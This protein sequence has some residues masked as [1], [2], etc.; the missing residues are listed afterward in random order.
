MSTPQQSTTQAH[1]LE[2]SPG[3]QISL[4][5]EPFYRWFRPS[6]ASHGDCLRPRARD[7]VHLGASLRAEGGAIPSHLPAYPTPRPRPANLLAWDHWDVG[8]AGEPA[9]VLAHGTALPLYD[10][11]GSNVIGT[12]LRSRVERLSN[13]VFWRQDRLHLDHVRLQTCACKT[14]TACIQDTAWTLPDPSRKGSR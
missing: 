6:L 8:A 9:L 7:S 12:A 5:K 4:G 14:R 11:L 2:K 3:G 10:G 13:P 1:G